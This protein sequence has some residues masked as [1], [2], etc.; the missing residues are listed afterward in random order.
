[1][2]E[3]LNL[4]LKKSLTLEEMRGMETTDLE[5]KLVTLLGL[6]LILQDSLCFLIRPGKKEF[7]EQAIFCAQNGFGPLVL[8]DR[9]RKRY[10]HVPDLVYAEEV[11]LTLNPKCE[12]VVA[13]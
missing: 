9:L 1:M 8:R 12:R 4:L 13:R 5:A 7:V 11:L 3:I 10:H 6:K 2:I